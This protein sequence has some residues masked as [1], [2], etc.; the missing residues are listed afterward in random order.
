MPRARAG[1]PR[2][3]GQ[4][5]CTGLPSMPTSAPERLAPAGPPS[6]SPSVLRP[7]AVVGAR[8]GLL[9]HSHHHR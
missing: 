4:R 9:L 1:A 6:R 8:G 3:R 7:D 5:R 2:A